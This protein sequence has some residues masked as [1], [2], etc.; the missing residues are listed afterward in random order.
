MADCRSVSSPMEPGTK[1]ISDEDVDNTDFPFQE[2]VGCLMYLAVSTRPDIA[3]ATN[4]MARSVTCTRPNHVA[5]LKR[6]LRYLQ[7][8]LQEGFCDASY[9]NC[10]ETRRST[11]GYVFRFKGSLISWQIKLQTTVAVSTTEAEYM[12]ASAATKEALFLRKILND[13]GFGPQCVT[14]NCDN[15]GA[16]NLTKNALTVS[17]TKHVDITH[18]FVRN[19]VNRGE[20]SFKYIQTE[21]QL[22]DFLTKAL[23]PSKLLTILKKLCFVGWK[24]MSTGE[25]P[26]RYEGVTGLLEGTCPH[27]TVSSPMRNPEKI[28]CIPQSVMETLAR[29]DIHPPF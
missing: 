13:V 9:G 25:N 16:I 24:A 8:T 29:S 5:A 28:L 21:E 23:G 15:Q 20:L 26:S 17:R 1:L 10:E 6:I 12:A 11:T 14:I 4:C 22:A 19:P 7:E 27:I 3:Y 2:L 18:H